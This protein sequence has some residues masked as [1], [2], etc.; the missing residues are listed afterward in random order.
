MNNASI[1]R[2]KE[3]E[4]EREQDQKGEKEKFQLQ[5]LIEIRIGAHTLDNWSL[6]NRPKDLWC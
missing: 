1:E 6:D 3:R 2:E 5:S 4:R